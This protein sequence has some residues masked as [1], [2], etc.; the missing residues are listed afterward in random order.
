MFYD[1]QVSG[2]SVFEYPGIYFKSLCVVQVKLKCKDLHVD[3]TINFKIVTVFIG[4]R[5][6]ARYCRLFS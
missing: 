4:T 5:V 6:L 1:S 2:F 3:V